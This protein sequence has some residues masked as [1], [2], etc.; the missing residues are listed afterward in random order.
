MIESPQSRVEVRDVAAGLW[1]LWR[2][3]HPRW[4]PG[5]GWE[6]I[7]ASTGVEIAGETLVLDP[8]A[9][10][11]RCPGTHAVQ[12]ITLWACPLNARER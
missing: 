11:R 9:P 3:E 5:Q 6:P 8:L 4:K 2:V 7:V 12:W 10:S 1:I